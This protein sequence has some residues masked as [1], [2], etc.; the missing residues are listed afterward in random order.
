MNSQTRVA[1][2]SRSFSKHPVLRAELLGRYSNVRFN[3]G[4]VALSGDAL[5][6]FLG[7]AVKAITAL[8]RLDE[9][10]FA[11]L[12]NLRVVSK[13]GVGLDTIDLQ[14]M[15]KRGILLGWRGGVNRRSVAE[16]VV[17]AAIDLLHGTVAA[18][19]QLRAGRWKQIVG[20]QLSGRTVGIIGC[21]HIG[22]EVV[23]LLQPFDC[24]IV[25]HDMLDF[26]EF[27]GRF[28][29]EPVSLERLLAESDVV[30]VH[31]PLDSSTAGLL[32]AA[33]LSAMKKGS[34]L[35]NMARGGIVDEAALKRLLG[36]GAIA[37]AAF[38]V[39]HEEP[40]ADPELISMPDFIATPHIGGSTEEAILAMGRA[41]IDGLDSADLPSR[42]PGAVKRH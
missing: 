9:Q 14:A 20:R 11:S 22:K 24:R 26:P 27:Y 5:V 34:V 15:E 38:D 2:T 21:G 25:A 13:Y 32:D 18:N 40:P 42:I 12:P 8:E 4:G 37:G 3:D 41:A 39:F 6:A 17:A 36:S 10:V 33:R 23:A 16:M 29:V 31:L 35:I 28:G 1:V 30:T 19:Q 7:G